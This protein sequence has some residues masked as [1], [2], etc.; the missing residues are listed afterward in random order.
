MKI[1][2]IGAGN[3][4][5]TLGRLWVQ[6]GHQVRFGVRDPERVLPLLDELGSGASAGSARAAAAY[7]DVV[8]YAGPYSAWP[9][10][11]GDIAS[12]VQGK[13]IVDAANPYPPR[14]GDMAAAII[15]SGHGAAAYTASLLPGAHVIKAFN[16]IYWVDLRD[17]AFAPD[18][19]LAMPI[20]GDDPA[21]LEMVTDLARDAGFEPVV[22]GRLSQ[23]AALDPDSP[24]YAKSFTAAQVRAA[25]SL[26]SAVQGDNP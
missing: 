8:V 18:T 14:D 11:A 24:I 21:A 12:S 15:A 17:K 26:P 1:G 20:A 13:T 16:T 4:G 23:S 3:I 10:V 19:L 6:A 5:G 7:G 22:V 25:L 9:D 2:I